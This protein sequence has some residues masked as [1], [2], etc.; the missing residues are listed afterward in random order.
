MKASGILLSID[1]PDKNVLKIKPPLVI[2]EEH[3]DAFLKALGRVLQD[4]LLNR[5]NRTE[6]YQ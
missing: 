3:S 2:T 4:T 6:P 5:F 1:G